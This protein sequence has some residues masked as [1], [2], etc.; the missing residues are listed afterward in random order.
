MTD[1]ITSE[2]RSR[3]M[4]RIRSRDT[5]PELV[6]RRGLHRLGLRFRLHRRSLPGT[7][8][9]VL[10]QHRACVFVQGCF[11]HRHP[12]C[13]QATT[14]KSNLAF[15][16]DKFARNVARDR[17]SQRQLAA[18]GWRVLVVWECELKAD[19]EGTVARLAERLRSTPLAYDIGTVAAGVLQAAET[20]EEE[21]AAAAPRPLL[22]KIISGGQAGAERG[23]LAAAVE[24]RIP[25][26][27]HCPAGRLA[28]DGTIPSRYRLT[29]L[30]DG[31]PLTCRERQVVEAQATLIFAT[32]E[33]DGDSERTARFADIH[34]RP[35]LQVDPRQAAAVA[36]PQIG[37]WLRQWRRP[38]G[39]VLNV[40]G[41]PASQAAGIEA[42]VRRL[43]VA[44]LE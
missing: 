43:L 3:L 20:D 6:V 14:P 22:G 19:P 39:L 38:G 15:W 4:S 44:A 5:Q 23:G 28:E 27:G 17:Q 34:A 40:A 33:L 30:A 12:G 11:W 42:Q 7:P 32:G 10:R 37:G 1:T 18:L 9:L 16:H 2:Q 13:R 36:G 35:W 24:L 21:E 29:E 41:Q 25:H 31:D 8:D 26:G